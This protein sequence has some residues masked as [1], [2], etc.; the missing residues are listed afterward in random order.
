MSKVFRYAVL[1][2]IGLLPGTALAQQATAREASPA[3]ASSPASVEP[4]KAAISL[5]ERLP[6]DHW[7]IEVRDEITG[8]VSTQT[9]VV[10]EV[11][12]TDISV[13]FNI[14]RP[15]KTT[16]EGLNIVDRSWNSIRGGPWQYFPYDGN[17]GVQTPLTV[18]KTWPFN[19]TPSTARMVS[20][21]NGRARPRS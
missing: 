11:T 4:S 18:G 17:T 3:A 13:R 2:L 7:T 1:G 20:P 9:N 5:E 16:S 6:G 15:D 14:V 10:T 19:S 21:G 12:P 8:T